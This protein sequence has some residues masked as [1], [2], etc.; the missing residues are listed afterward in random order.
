MKGVLVECVATVV[1]CFQEDGVLNADQLIF[2]IS[3][4]VHKR[5]SFPVQFVSISLLG[6]EGVVWK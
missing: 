5:A 2:H 4:Y 6:W 3:T 1:A